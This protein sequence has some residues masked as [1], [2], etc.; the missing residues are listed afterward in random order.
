[1]FIAIICEIGW[2][3]RDPEWFKTKSWF[4]KSSSE[5]VL[6]ILIVYFDGVQ[7]APSVTPVITQFIHSGSQLDIVI[8]T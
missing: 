2:W 7:I 8:N 4:P 6:I 1:M 5:S 3:F